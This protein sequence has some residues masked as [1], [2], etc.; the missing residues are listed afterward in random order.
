MRSDFVLLMGLV[1]LSACTP[2]SNTL[3]PPATLNQEQVEKA[4]LIPQKEAADV[5]RDYTEQ[6]WPEHP[7][8]CA[9][10]EF[11]KF[12]CWSG[13]SKPTPISIS[14]VTKLEF[15]VQA[16]AKVLIVHATNSS[17][18]DGIYR[19]NLMNSYGGSAWTDE[20]KI[21][22]TQA[23]IALGATKLRVSAPKS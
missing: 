2:L 11:L 15:G 1:V 22:I 23:F 12:S 21:R 9:D 17:V 16:F 4:T 6:T 13:N 10:H 7:F 8:V 19:P 20:V 14:D 5:I 18:T 3:T